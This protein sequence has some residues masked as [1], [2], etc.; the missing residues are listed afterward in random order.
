MDP[1]IC[2]CRLFLTNSQDTYLKGKHSEVN[3]NWV[4][5]LRHTLRRRL[6]GNI[7]LDENNIT[8]VDFREHHKKGRKGFKNRRKRVP[9]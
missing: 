7:V 9:L 6:T 5:K 2:G 4:R 1:A 3:P 8:K